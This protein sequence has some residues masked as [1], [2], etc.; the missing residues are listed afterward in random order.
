MSVPCRQRRVVMTCV[1]AVFFVF[2]FIYLHIILSCSCT[3]SRLSTE[4]F[5]RMF[6]K[7]HECLYLVPHMYLEIMYRIKETGSVL[8][9]FRIFS[10]CG[11]NRYLIDDQCRRRSLPN[12]WACRV[13]A[14]KNSHRKVPPPTAVAAHFPPPPPYLLLPFPSCLSSK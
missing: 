13:S 2:C 10:R 1:F 7:C 12:T 14:Q 5:L 11:C 9:N 8:R 6:Y 3:A 4:C